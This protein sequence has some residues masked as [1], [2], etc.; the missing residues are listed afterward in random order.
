MTRWPALWRQ[1]LCS[2]MFGMVFSWMIYT[3]QASPDACFCLHVIFSTVTKKRNPTTSKP[4]NPKNFQ[5]PVPFFALY[6]SFSC[7]GWQA[8]VGASLSE[9][10][11]LAHW[12]DGSG[13]GGGGRGGRGPGLSPPHGGRSSSSAEAGLWGSGLALSMQYCIRVFCCWRFYY[14]IV[15]VLKYMAGTG[16]PSW[17]GEKSSICFWN[18]ICKV[19]RE[20]CGG[21]SAGE[22]GGQEPEQDALCFETRTV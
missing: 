8:K 18:Q 19:E 7:P 6:P 12:E 21:V 14:V 5:K 11:S 3:Q 20:G 22:G 15:T 16:S 9:K 1:D 13:G 17:E 2:H 4:Q 10:I